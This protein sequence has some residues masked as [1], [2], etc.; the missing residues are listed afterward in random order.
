LLRS[1]EV[2]KKNQLGIDM[3]YLAGDDR[4]NLIKGTILRRLPEH[5]ALSKEQ[6]ETAVECD[7]ATIKDKWSSFDYKDYIGMDMP[8]LYNNMLL[9]SLINE[10]KHPSENA[11]IV[12]RGARA[13]EFLSGLG[14]NLQDLIEF[15]PMST[16]G[17]F[18][19]LRVRP[20]SGKEIT[21][22]SEQFNEMHKDGKK[23]VLVDDSHVNPMR[24]KRDSVIDQ[25]GNGLVM[26]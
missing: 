24:R 3:T 4:V 1:A 14:S 9:G 16:R 7:M 6:L 11:P 8:T 26:P 15:M 19:N 13:E 2:A 5:T 23:R 21:L 22:T 25:G 20:Q 12:E 18:D 10:R 17:M